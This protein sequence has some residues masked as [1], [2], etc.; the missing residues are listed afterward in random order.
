[1]PKLQ[2][3]LNLKLAGF[4]AADHPPVPIPP[5][6]EP[7]RKSNPFIRCPLPPFNSSPDS[8]RQFNETGKIPTR[9]VIPLPVQSSGGSQTTVENN[10]TIIQ[11]GSGGGSSTSPQVATISIPYPAL[12][13][14]GTFPTVVQ[15]ARSFQ[16]LHISA[17]GIIEVRLY[18]S[19]QAQGIDI[20]R[21]TD[22]APPFE[23]S[24]GIITDVVLDTYPFSW[25][26][27]DRLGANTETPQSSNIYVTFVSP[28]EIATDPGNV[29]IT[30]LPLLN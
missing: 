3:R 25:S 20:A 15:M 28:G 21:E 2:D 27:A 4:A 14:D 23:V 19:A 22:A 9:R 12:G 24:Q 26:W 10:T 7:E 16:L 13:T 18:G 6:S 17:S 29:V 11:Q 5:P 8:L 30:Y 1:M